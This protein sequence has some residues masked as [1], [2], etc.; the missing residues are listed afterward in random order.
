[1]LPMRNALVAMALQILLVF[2]SLKCRDARSWKDIS[3]IHDL[4]ALDTGAL[5]YLQ[6]QKVFF[7]SQY[8]ALDTTLQDRSPTTLAPSPNPSRR[9]T[10]L[11]TVKPIDFPTIAPTVDLYR[12]S[13]PPADPED[14]YFNYDG[15]SPYGPGGDVT[16]VQSVTTGLFDAHMQDNHWGEVSR[17]PNDYWNEFGDD[18]F[19]PWRG[20][21]QLYEPSKN[22][23][24]TG[25]M[26]SPIDV[27]DNGAA[28]RERHQIRH[29]P[30]D[31]TVNGDHVGKSIESNKLRLTFE[32][33][34]C[35]NTTL[36][37]CSEPDPPHADFPHGWGGFADLLHIDVKV[38]SEHTLLNEHFD[39]EMQYYHIHQGRRRLA[40]LSIL[41][42]ATD[43]GYNYYFQAILDAFH[44]VY[45]KNIANCRLRLLEQRNG[46]TNE[47]RVLANEYV[48]PYSDYLTWA[49]SFGTKKSF[50]DTVWDPYH[51][52]LL[53]TIYF[54]RYEGSLTEPPCG[55]FVSWWIADTPI[56]ISLDQLEELKRLIFTNV[57]QNCK[58][59]GVQFRQSVARPIQKSNNRPVWRCTAKEFGPDP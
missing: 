49:K 30:G 17:P 10:K 19:G 34:P 46:T 3:R 45:N 59:T 28:C 7:A 13:V 41:I 48:T 37:K 29:L 20:T 4:A 51:E 54:Y 39:A 56:T 27:R 52:M 5:I 18:G 16:L 15:S 26:Q 24:A 8:D 35:S 32:R 2:G 42:R 55:E 1:M 43:N 21:L 40:A 9:A 23:C 36:D 58:R 57:D 47:T 22:R 33:R 44:D 6:Q 53:P 25:Q 11:P 38:P 12:D 50:E 31:F 14:W